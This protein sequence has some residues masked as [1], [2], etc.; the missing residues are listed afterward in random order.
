M[1]SIAAK[2]QQGQVQSLWKLISDESQPYHHI[3]R[4]GFLAGIT[5]LFLG[6]IGMLEAFNEREVIRD[7]VTL[8]QFVLFVPTFAAAYMAAQRIREEQ[9]IGMVLVAATIIGLL[10]AIPTIVILLINTQV[11][12]RDMFVHVNR[13]WLEIITFDNRNQLGLGIGLL[14]G[15]L[16]L[17]GLLG[18]VLQNLPQKIRRSVIFGL[19][20]MLV[21]GVMSETVGLIMQEIFTDD[22]LDNFFKRDTLLLNSAIGLFVFGVALIWVPDKVRRSFVFG[23]VVAMV[24]LGLRN[25]LLAIDSLTSIIPTSEEGFLDVFLYFLLPFV[26]GFAGRLYLEYGS[27]DSNKAKT[28]TKATTSTGRPIRVDLIVSIAILLVAPWI[29]GRALSDVMVTIGIFVLMGIGLNV[30]VGLAGLLDLGYVTNYAVGAYVLAVMTST[31]PLGLFNSQ[32]GVIVNFWMVIPVALLAAMLAGF[33]FAVPVLKMRGD[34]LAIATLGFGEII[35]RLAVSDA[36]APIIGGAQGMSFIPKP[37]LLGFTL[38]D[39]EQL[40][41]IILVACAITLIVSIRLNNSRTGRQWMAIR[42]D[43]D[44]ASAMGINVAQAKLLAFTISAATGGVAGAIFAAKVGTVF[45]NSFS[46][47]V[48]INVLSLIIVGGMGSNPG[49]VVGAI[50]LIG[51]PE[52]LRE[53]SDFRWLMY[54]ALLIWMMNNRPDGLWPS[55]VR[56]RELIGDDSSPPADESPMMASE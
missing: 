14:L 48:S 41:Y 17:A 8:A 54:G 7:V 29:V 11:N 27:R 35:G 19:S 52:L 50:V 21:I 10:S 6:L 46:V 15:S 26:A 39:P 49:I 34:Y 45:P 18:A 4:M 33:V 16:G 30:A 12:I 42:E 51:L 2:N 23:L 43:E 38:K 25:L 55:Q 24:A 37:E 9:S 22:F 5:L 44:V 13:D 1:T 56:R 36:L 53:F 20:L 32:E 3:L 47:I 28:D 31:G 40:Y